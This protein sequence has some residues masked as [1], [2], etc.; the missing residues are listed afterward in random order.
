MIVGRPL[1]NL[2]LLDAYGAFYL[3]KIDLEY[4]LINALGKLTSQLMYKMHPEWSAVARSIYSRCNCSLVDG[5][6]EQVWQSADVFIFSSATTTTFEYSLCSNRPVV[7]FDAKG[8]K[9]KEDVKSK[10]T[11][12]CEIV[13]YDVDSY[14][15]AI[16]DQDEIENAIVQAGIKKLDRSFIES[17]MW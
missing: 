7:L 10:L 16:L 12:R 13:E 2:R 6:F 17:F 9:W 5:N 15:K 1:N 3:H 14:G 8:N 4:Q 11:H